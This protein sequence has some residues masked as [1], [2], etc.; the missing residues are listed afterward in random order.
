MIEALKKIDDMVKQKMRS[1]ER[2]MEII[3]SL[4]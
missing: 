2:K 3:G 1:T 4:V